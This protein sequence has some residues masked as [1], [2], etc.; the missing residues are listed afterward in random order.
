MQR[1][2]I[3]TKPGR[4]VDSGEVVDNGDTNAEGTPAIPWAW[5]GTVLAQTASSGGA[6]SRHGQIVRILRPE[7][8]RVS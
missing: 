4:T 6:T 3:S 8:K 5:S 2:P 7:S 1:R